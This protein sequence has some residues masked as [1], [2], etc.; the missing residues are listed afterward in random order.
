MAITLSFVASLGPRALPWLGRLVTIAIVALLAWLG[1]QVFWNLT[2][3]ATPEPPIAV[4]TDPPRVAQTIAARHLFGEAPQQG[5]RTAGTGRAVDAKLYGVV[6]ASGKGH[7][8]IAILSIQGKPAVAVREGDEITPGVTL[9]R[10]LARSVEISQGGVIEVLR[11]PE[12]G[13]T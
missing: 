8:G 2:A 6:A 13:K 7:S 11:L 1:A 10:V 5:I 4:D 12:R 3:P 9:H